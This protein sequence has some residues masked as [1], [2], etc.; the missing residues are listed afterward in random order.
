MTSKINGPAG[1]DILL[2][3]GGNRIPAGGAPLLNRKP[4]SKHE[5]DRSAP[6][7]SSAWLVTVVLIAFGYSG[8]LSGHRAKT[9]AYFTDAGGIAVT[10][11]MSRASRWSAVSAVVWPETVQKVTFSVDHPSIVVGDQSWPR[12]HRHHPR[13]ALHRGQSGW[14]RQADHD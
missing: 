6:A 8:L 13:R 1:S 9:D 10:R 2:P 5:R 7:A 11:F 4:S 3:I 14:L 12:S